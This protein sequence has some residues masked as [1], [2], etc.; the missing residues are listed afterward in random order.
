MSCDSNVRIYLKKMKII[1]TAKYIH[2]MY[3]TING[4]KF[5]ND[6]KIK[7]FFPIIG[8]P[9]IFKNRLKGIFEALFVCDKSEI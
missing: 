5:I 1:F 6:I 4:R 3:Y 7:A 2:F 8:D 9:Y